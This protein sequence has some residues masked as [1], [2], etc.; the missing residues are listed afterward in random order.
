MKMELIEKFNM[1]VGTVL[2][3]KTDIVLNVGD[4]IRVDEKEYI[5]KGFMHPTGSYDDQKISV[6]V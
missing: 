6:I 1:S 4:K 3:I 2:L 5:I